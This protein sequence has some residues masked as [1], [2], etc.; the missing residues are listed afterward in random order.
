VFSE[1]YPMDRPKIGA[2]DVINTLHDEQ[3]ATQNDVEH[4]KKASALVGLEVSTTLIN[5][6][7]K[8]LE[9]FSDRLELRDFGAY[10]SYFLTAICHGKEASKQSVIQSRVSYLPFIHNAFDTGTKKKKF[11][12]ESCL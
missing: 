9:S 10:N 8:Q 2:H 5:P 12:L 3:P 11:F 7:L 4:M 6:T 1:E